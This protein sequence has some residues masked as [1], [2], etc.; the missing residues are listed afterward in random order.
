[1]SRYT[2]AFCGQSLFFFYYRGV[3][4]LVLIHVSLDTE[5][6]K[7]EIYREYALNSYMMT[8]VDLR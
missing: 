6:L 8:V 7:V 2:L 4:Y 1:M 3:V 5:Y